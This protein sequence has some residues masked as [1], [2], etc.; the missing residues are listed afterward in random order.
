M[1]EPVSLHSFCKENGNL[2]K[3]SVRRW[4]NDNGYST[5]NGLSPAAVEA[6]TAQFCR[7]VATSKPI[8]GGL[9]IHTG[10][11]CTSIDLPNY[12]GMT[13]DLAQFRDSE[14]L[15]IDDP[16]AVAEQF[17]Q[18]ADLI[19]GA[20]ADDIAAREQRLQATKQA[21]SK[22]AAKAQELALEQRL[23]RLQTSQLDAAQTDE[24]KS[25]AD[26]LGTLKALGKSTEPDTAAA[27]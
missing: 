22:I 3:T 8:V 11:H 15:V 2:P 1:T 6:A 25:L 17:L 9:T 16:L 10:N 14:A 27:G 18:T 20:L 19:Q 4:L 12:Q 5:S 7:P 24:T 13:I 23:Y 21:Q 26:A